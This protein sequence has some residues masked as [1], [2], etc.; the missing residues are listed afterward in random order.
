[1]KATPRQLP[2]K[3]LYW[4][5]MSQIL[6]LLLKSQTVSNIPK[7]AKKNYNQ[8][9]K[10]AIC[11]HKTDDI[12]R[13]ATSSSSSSD[14]WFCNLSNAAPGAAFGS[15]KNRQ[16]I[17]SKRTTQ[18]SVDFDHEFGS[19]PKHSLQYQM[20]WKRDKRKGLKKCV[21]IEMLLGMYLL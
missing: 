3:L 2:I 21:S 15:L 5:M 7:T 17:T 13:A 9:N 6:K 4:A 18:G 12:Y 1:M 20:L 8:S 10:G 19:L 16:Y 14:C 11:D